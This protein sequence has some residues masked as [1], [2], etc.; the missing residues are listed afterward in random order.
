MYQVEWFREL[1]DDVADEKFIGVFS[2]LAKAQ[3]ALDKAKALPGFR[4][5]PECLSL[6]PIE[7]DKDYWTEGFFTPDE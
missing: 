2:N 4:D 5:H 6:G 3:D 7:L 1:S